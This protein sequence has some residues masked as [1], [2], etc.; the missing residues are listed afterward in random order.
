[1]SWASR[2]GD[3]GFSINL[4]ARLTE[5]ARLSEKEIQEMFG[6]FNPQIARSSEQIVR[7]VHD[8]RVGREIFSWLIIAFAGLLGLEYIV[9]NWFYKPE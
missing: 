2:S 5:L 6:P 4:P 7:N 1:M 3:R 8:A 9:S